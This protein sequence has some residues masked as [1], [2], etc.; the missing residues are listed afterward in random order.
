MKRGAILAAVP[1][2]A[3]LLLV[4]PARGNDASRSEVEALRTEVAQLR[5]MVMQLTQ[6]LRAMDERLARLEGRPGQDTV[7]KASPKVRVPEKLERGSQMD[8]IQQEQRLREILRPRPAPS[9]VP[10]E[11]EKSQEPKR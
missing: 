4:M 11:P 9:V 6:Q 8:P 2:V 3:V 5:A 10:G 1:I 7:E